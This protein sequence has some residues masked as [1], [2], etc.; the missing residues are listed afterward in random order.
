MSYGIF[1]S[2]CSTPLECLIDT[3]AAVSLLN[4]D[5]WQRVAGY[6]VFPPIEKWTGQMLVGMNRSAL[7][8]KGVQVYHCPWKV[9]YSMY[10]L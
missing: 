10:H 1:A 5:V 8:V 3:G 6:R 9:T 2:I 4:A 7:S